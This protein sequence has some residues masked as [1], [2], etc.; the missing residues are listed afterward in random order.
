MCIHII[1]NNNKIYLQW[2]Y[3]HYQFTLIA[4]NLN[5][6]L[7]S[8]KST[9]FV[10]SYLESLEILKRVFKNTLSTIED[11][12]RLTFKKESNNLKFIKM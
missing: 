8:S 3:Q 2:H 10:P 11:Y 7:Y 6:K 9:T 1:L 4:V 5:L 12:R